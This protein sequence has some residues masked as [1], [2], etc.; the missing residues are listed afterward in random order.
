[1]SL[2]WHPDK[3]NNKTLTEFNITAAEAEARFIDISKAY[4]TLTDDEA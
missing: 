3:V 1:L 4:K 2:K